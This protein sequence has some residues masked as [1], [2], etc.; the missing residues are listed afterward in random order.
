MSIIQIDSPQNATIKSV[1]K[2]RTSRGRQQQDRIIIDGDREVS[3][4]IACG[5]EI[6]SVFVSDKH[7]SA[8]SNV[9]AERWSKTLSKAASDAIVY[10]VNERA[11]SKIAFGERHEIVAVAKTPQ[12]SLD[13]LQLGN[14]PQLIA[15]L[16][17]IEKPGNVGAV[18]RSADAAGL[19]ALILV[20]P[21]TDLFNP[22]AIRASLGTIFSLNI[23]TTT[24]AE[25]S[26]WAKSHGYQHLLAKCDTT[27]KDYCDVAGERTEAGNVAIVLG[28]EAK[29]LSGNWDGAE[30]RTNITIPMRGIADSLNISASAAV[31]FYEYA[32]R[33]RSQNDESA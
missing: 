14:S 15:V 1:A 8:S 4:A 28:C 12:R 32:K 20:E 16:E 24:F 9:R 19:D 29:G 7:D 10:S 22:N 33:F 6:E 5:I 30:N 25:Y 17:S 26:A 31:L 23:A 2:L 3:R 13:N 27:A 18:M 21:V 11:L